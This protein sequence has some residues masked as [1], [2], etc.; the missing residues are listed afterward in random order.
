MEPLH[1]LRRDIRAHGW[2]AAVAAGM[3]ATAV[4]V[5]VTRIDV[6]DADVHR[7]HSD[8]W[9][10]WMA[11]IVVCASLVGRRRWPLRTCAVAL[12]L[13]LPLELAH[14]RDTVVFFADVLAVYSVA[15]YRPL[16]AALRVVPMIAALYAVTAL[17]GAMVITSAPLVGPLFLVTAFA[18]GCLLRLGREHQ[19][20][21]V[22]AAVERAAELVVSAD[23]QAADE[24]LRMAQELHDVVAHSLSVIAVQA[25][26][27][28]HLV[29]RRPVEAAR[30]LDAIRTTSHTAAGEISRLVDILRDGGAAEPALAAPAMAAPTIGGVI[31]LVEQ[32]R[33]AG[34][35]VTL[36]TH[37]SLDT[38]PAGVSL[39]AYRIVQE[40]L[41]N[42]VRHAGR[43]H[44]TVTVHVG[45]EQV[46]LRV[47]DDGHGDRA[48]DQAAPGG[49]GPDPGHGLSGMRERA[50]LYD[51]TMRSGPRPGGGFRV[52]AT[53]R[54]GAVPTRR[55]EPVA[56]LAATSPSAGS[57][58]R[59]L[60]LPPLLW[61][62][63][64]AAAMVALATI[65]VV[66]AG[67]TTVPYRPADLWSWSLRILCCLTLV[68]RRRY[69]ATSL[70][71]AWAL[72]LPLGIGDYKVG[73]VVFVLWLGVYT[74]A[75]RASTRRLGGALL[76]TY[77]GLAAIAWSELPDLT[78]SGAV[79]L[80]VLFTATVVAGYTVRRDR[81]R[82]TLERTHREDA[83]DV[84]ARR[85]LLVIATE[86][87][88]I[89]DELSAI[90]RRSID[91]ITQEA[92]SGSQMAELDPTAA[93]RTL[94]AI[95]SIS[96]EALNDV[97]RLLERLRTESELPAYAPIPSTAV[98]PDAVP[99][100]ARR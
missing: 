37:G 35:P 96:R 16:R 18:V 21:D 84:H 8:T 7:F 11:T 81:E 51:G 44:A 3:V 65:E 73:V 69:P 87:L 71:A 91:A 49:R 46:E 30:A 52:D 1:A 45:D 31:E 38:V 74:A 100:G 77:A 27:G 47:D 24:R 88:R 75:S 57:I 23:L 26:I 20:R 90:I 42:V 85:A 97:R 41:T 13:T 86:R 64:L 43:A 2:D 92:G 93:R 25:G 19:D 17:A 55:D 78:T 14:H 4:L 68:A 40:A 95:S 58:S 39:A 59:G 6:E 54:Y 94:E 12:V 98:G 63:A 99:A 33:A 70:A 89:A 50:E 48:R 15:A 82:R 53:L 83:A 28:A 80:G 9:W 60:H 29:D 34:V 79:W 76:A 10:G 61:D 22:R 72:A 67:P 62:G 66:T 5:L 32:I 56:A 36:T